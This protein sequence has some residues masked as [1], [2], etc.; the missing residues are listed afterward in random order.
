MR[1]QGPVNDVAGNVWQVLTERSGERREWRERR[2]E[3]EGVRG[4]RGE[5]GGKGD[6]RGEERRRRLGEIREEREREG[7]GEGRGESRG[8]RW[9]GTRGQRREERG[10][11]RV[12]RGERRPLPPRPRARSPSR[13]PRS[14]H[15]SAPPPRRPRGTRSARLRPWR[16]RRGGGTA[17]A[18]SS[19][20][21][22]PSLP[23]PAAVPRKIA[24]R[25]GMKTAWRWCRKQHVFRPITGAVWVE[26]EQT[27][28]T[29]LAAVYRYTITRHTCYIFIGDR[30]DL[31]RNVIPNTCNPLLR[32]TRPIRWRDSSF[33]RF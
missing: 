28:R 13:A 9:R 4:E 30:P 20:C 1:V 8:Q 10:E 6:Q 15:P 16:R 27:V 2:E 5:R 11:R 19:S 23:L 12:E 17:G 24:R 26:Y 22:A 33:G 32:S 14:S 3:R 31:K 21:F 29:R 25:K 7:R 18:P